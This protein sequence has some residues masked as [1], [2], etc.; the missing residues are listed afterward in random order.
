MRRLATLLVLVLAL[1]ACRDERSTGP[2]VLGLLPVRADTATGTGSEA[3]LRQVKRRW[4]ETRGGRDYRFTTAYYCFCFI[5]SQRPAQVF[6]QGARVVQVRDAATG[7]TRREA[8]YYTIESL[9]DRAI[10][11]REQGGR[12][13]VRWQLD[14]GYPAW[15]EIGT[16][17]NDAGASYD[18]S[19]VELD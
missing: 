9:L 3:E 5:A 19:N 15:I 7:M 14:A 11:V 12:V 8:D 6:V 13:R 17:E 2:G 18:L 4:V 1:A 10:E 16:P